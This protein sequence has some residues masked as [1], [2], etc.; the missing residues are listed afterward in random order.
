MP[1]KR[2]NGSTASL[3]LTYS[4]TRRS[5]PMPLSD[6]PRITRVAIC[7]IGTPVALL[8]NGTVREPRGFT[9]STYSW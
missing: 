8:T 7:A 5:R 1:G 4:G 3:T 9:S 2:L 6:S